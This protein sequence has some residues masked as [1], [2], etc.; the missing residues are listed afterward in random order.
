MRRAL[1]VIASVVL[2]LGVGVIALLALLP[3]EKI[4]QLAADQVKS[5]TG[6]TL[7]IS[8]DVSPSFYPVIGVETGAIALSNAEWG[9]SEDMVTASGTKIGVE[10]IPLLSGNIRVSEVR[11]V[12]PVITLEVNEEGAANWV[13]DAAADSTAAPAEGESFVKEISLGEA[14]IENGAVSFSDRSTG[15]SVQL[16]AINATIALA[17]LDAPLEVD[18]SALWNGEETDLSLYVATPAAA[19]A[20]T[21]VDLR[22]DLGAA[23]LSVAF[24]GT[25]TPPAANQM[26]VATGAF[27]IN[28]GDPGAAMTWATGQPAPPA[29]VGITDLVAEGS[30]AV[31]PEGASIDMTGS[32]KRD[33]QTATVALKASGGADFAAN[34]ALTVDL[35]AEIGS[36]GALSY[37]GTLAPSAGAVPVSLKGQYDLNASDPA[38]VMRWATGS[39]P[40]GLTGLSALTLAGAIDLGD[41]GLSATAKGGV[42]RD[43]ARAVVDLNAK[44]GADWATKRAFAVDVT[45]GVD[46]LADL[47]FSGNVA[48]PDGAGPSAS[49][50][51]TVD[52]PDLQQL[53]AFAGTALPQA[54]PGAYRALSLSG[55]L[56]APSTDKISFD[57]DKLVFDDITA[58]GQFTASL[59]ATPTIGANLSTGALDLT[60]Y[61]VGQE[62]GPSGPGW[63][64]E[65]IDLSALGT[66]NGDFAIRAASVTLPQIDLGTSDLTAKLRNG[67]LDLTIRELGL[68]GGG[69]KG[70][71]AVDG[72]NGNAIKANISASAVRLLPMLKALADME[73]IEGTGKFRMNV[74]GSGASLHDIMN[75][76]NGKGNVK[77]K[78]GALVGYNLA[79]MVRNVTNAFTGDDGSTARTDFS[80][81]AATFDI[82]QG[83]LSNADF[84]FLGPLLRIVGE[85][86]VDLG[87]QA[88]NFRLT[89]KAVASLKGQGG[90]LDTKG[91]SFPVLITGPW[92]DLSFR[93]DLQGGIENLLKDPEGA[94][95]ALSNV[96]D[97]LSGAGTAGAA[98]VATEVLKNATKGTGG[99]AEVLKN[100]TGGNPE[101][102]SAIEQIIGGGATK[103]YGPLIKAAK[104]EVDAA[105]ASGDKKR[106]KAARQELKKLRAER[107]AAN[108][109]KKANPVSGLLKQLGN[110]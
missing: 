57:A 77:L 9:T 51:L 62:S 28:A 8:G 22:V 21:S 66:L 4:A 82:K 80:E 92:S 14:V 7:V 101:V 88:V 109:A 60:P 50:K 24:D 48:A 38:A 65:A 45:G 53:A 47:S 3:S 13:F 102:G 1:K 105:K 54:G 41:A 56:N 98:G 104:Q 103:D 33:G 37:N 95:D 17:A 32:A 93:P 100:A 20:G 78:N 6:R 18:G 44:S 72:R 5:A 30:A 91:L 106:L 52:A 25:V 75:S 34:P 11:L 63:S 97:G 10:L 27:S 12:D 15:Q 107:K 59:G 49:G 70:D 110:N 96:V 94:V 36:I 87:G 19:M 29:L 23:P 35:G 40:E 85:G 67:K 39:A 43:G 55:T 76:L 68:Y 73:S 64:K 16:E 79:A 2:L 99:A 84:S 42:S 31:S 46:G 89:P 83:V 81:V 71:I 74:T 61:M 58:S 90:S 26:L 108:E 86:T 69:L